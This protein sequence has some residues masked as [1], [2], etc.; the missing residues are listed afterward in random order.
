[1]DI[2]SYALSKKYTADTADSL[3]SLRGAPCTVKSIEDIT[4]GKKITLEWTGTSGAKQTQSFN[5]MN[6][7]DGKYVSGAE[8]NSENHL[9]ITLSDGTEIDCGEVPTVK[10]DT[11]EDGEDGF[12]PVITVAQNTENTYKLHIKTAD[13]EF[14]TPNLKGSGGGGGANV[15]VSGESLIF[16]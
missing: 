14:D 6:G 10:G 2:V 1:M 12:S 7:T 16:S 4:G 3:G 5:L 13:D 8:V 15:E 9:I 11:G